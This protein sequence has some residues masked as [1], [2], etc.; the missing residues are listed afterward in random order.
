[1]NKSYWSARLIENQ[2]KTGTKRMFSQLI[3][4]YQLASKELQACIN[5]LWLKML[6]DGSLT[7]GGIY[8]YD[9]YLKLQ[10][11]V[12]KIL[13]NLGQEEINIINL[14]LQ[15]LYEA[16]FIE[17]ARYLGDESLDSFSL[18]NTKTAKEV[19][20]AN[21]KGATYSNRI[22]HRQELLKEQLTRVITN[23][24]VLGIDHKRV[25]RD[26][27]ARLDVSLEDSRQLVRTETIRVLNSA[28]TNS[29]IER[30]YKTYHNLIENDACDECKNEYEN[31]TFNLGEGNPP[32]LHPNCRCCVII[33]LD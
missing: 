31:K 19:V 11:Q 2:Y 5:D 7:Q 27:A 15:S 9:R 3:K 21:F 6:E 26:L 8:R 33:D 20:N 30:G 16:T 23:S 4:V 29:A 28:C 18:L 14:Q 12:N 24:A 17:S 25:A 32:P 13:T 1:M 10:Q 22:W